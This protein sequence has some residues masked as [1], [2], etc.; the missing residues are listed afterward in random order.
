M[1]RRKGRMGNLG[2]ETYK[3]TD[4][5][6]SDEE[7]KVLRNSEVKWKELRPLVTNPELYDEM[8]SEVRESTRKN[9][10]LALLK[11]RIEKLGEEGIKLAK[12]VIDLV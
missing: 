1:T 4:E 6:L 10:D 12:E 2:D 5:E 11:G 8:I 3:R 9:E 7:A